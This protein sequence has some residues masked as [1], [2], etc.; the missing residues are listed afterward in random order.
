MSPSV[1]RL[2][3]PSAGIAVVAAGLDLQRGVGAGAGDAAQAVGVG[4]VVVHQAGDHGAAAVGARDDERVEH[5]DRA[6][7]VVHAAAG[8]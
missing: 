1:A 2:S 4:L 8:L 5:V 6:G 3:I 7:A